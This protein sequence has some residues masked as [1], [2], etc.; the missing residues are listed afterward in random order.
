MIPTGNLLAIDAKRIKHADK[1]T[2]LF[3]KGE[4]AGKKVG[5]QGTAPKKAMLPGRPGLEGVVG[6]PDPV[7]ER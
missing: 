2:T 5:D 3:T 6:H 4:I 1:I 7:D